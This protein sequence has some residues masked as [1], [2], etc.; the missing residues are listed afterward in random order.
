ME[1]LHAEMI[2]FIIVFFTVISGIVAK[3]VISYLKEKGII[4]KLNSNKELVGIAVRAVEQTYKHLHGEEKL[5]LAKIEVIKLAKSK[6]I[7]I[8]EKELDLM[9]ESSVRE[10]NK[11]VKEE[12]S[13]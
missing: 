5:N 7:K 4:S 12:L 6:G 8:S 9:I 13:K 3:Y 2:N 11:S 10:M 1:V